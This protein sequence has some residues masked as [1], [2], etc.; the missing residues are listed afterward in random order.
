[1]KLCVLGR[2]PI[3]KLEEMARGLFS[4]VENKSVDVPDLSQPPAYDNRNL[5]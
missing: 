3:D 4:Q 1:M 2:A 5:G